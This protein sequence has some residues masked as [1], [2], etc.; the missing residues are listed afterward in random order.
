MWVV[1]LNAVAV[2]PLGRV[3]VKVR[4]PAVEPG[5]LGLATVMVYVSPVSP[6][7]KLPL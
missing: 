4:V 1:W 2:R 7:V 6:W 3:S 5:P